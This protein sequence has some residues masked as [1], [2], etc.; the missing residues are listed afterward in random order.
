MASCLLASPVLTSTLDAQAAKAM[1][2]AGMAIAIVAMVAGTWM[3]RL[4]D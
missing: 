4:H 3:A 1:V 2:V